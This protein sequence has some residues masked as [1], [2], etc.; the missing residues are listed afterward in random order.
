MMSSTPETALKPCPVCG[1]PGQARHAPF[2]SKRCAD[3][4]LGRWLKGGYAIAGETDTEA[5]KPDTSD[6][7]EG[8][9]SED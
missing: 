3:I 6:P 7:D 9:A 5:R 4:D 8:Q 1:K 2:C